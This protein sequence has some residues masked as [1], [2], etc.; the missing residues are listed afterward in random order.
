MENIIFK[1]WRNRNLT[2]AFTYYWHKLEFA[3][4]VRGVQSKY[5]M[6]STLNYSTHSYSTLNLFNN[7]SIEL[8][9]YNSRIG[10][11]SYAIFGNKWTGC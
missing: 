2:F 7:I 11:S 10:G 8:C 4:E 3:T 5:S 1:H 9:S 6:Y